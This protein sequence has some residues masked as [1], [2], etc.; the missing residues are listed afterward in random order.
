MNTANITGLGLTTV[1]KVL[2]PRLSDELFK[3]V[4]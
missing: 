1:L 3:K 2:A 4:K